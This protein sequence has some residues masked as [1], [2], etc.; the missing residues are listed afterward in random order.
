M[1]VKYTNAIKQRNN[2]YKNVYLCELAAGASGGSFDLVWFHQWPFLTWISGHYSLLGEHCTVFY[3]VNT[4][5]SLA[6][7]PTTKAFRL[8][9]VY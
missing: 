4:V 7:V 5:S 2:L 1:R 6:C 9:T 3:S 8:K